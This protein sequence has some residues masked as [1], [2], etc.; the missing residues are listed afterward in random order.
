LRGAVVPIGEYDQNPQI[1][2]IRKSS[3]TE[4][5][6][7]HVLTALFPLGFSFTAEASWTIDPP[8]TPLHRVVDAGR[9]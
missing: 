6:S 4:L 7:A 3:P 8:S 9:W 2:A 5:T 1:V